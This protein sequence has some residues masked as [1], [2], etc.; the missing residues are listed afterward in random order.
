MAKK[1]QNAALLLSHALTDEK[2]QALENMAHSLRKNSKKIIT[3][4][5]KDLAMGK[6]KK[7]SKAL[8]D[9]LLLDEERIEKMA[10]SLEEII[11][12]PDPVGKIIQE[13]QPANRI[14]FK[15]IRIP[16]G[17]IGII[18][19]SRP[20]VTA[21][22]AGLCLKSG[23]AVILRGG[24]EAFHSNQ[25][26]ISLLSQAIQEANLPKE[27][28]QGPSSQDRKVI[29]HLLKLDS[30]I[31]LIIP[32]GG[33]ALVER[34][35]QKSRIPVLKHFKGICH[36]YLDE[37]ANPQMALDITLNAK[38][39]RPGVCNAIETLLVH[40]SL[41]KSILSGILQSLLESGVE[42]RADKELQNQ[43]PKIKLVKEK[44]F[45]NE[46]LDLILPIKIVSSIDEAIEHIQ[47][48]G[49]KHTE[50]IVT[51]NQENAERFI[52]EL[53]SSCIFVNAS[54][55]FADGG[56]MGM[57]A[58]IGISTSKIHAFGP[59]GLEDLT[60]ARYVGYGEG[61]IRT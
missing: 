6:G 43:F 40:K 37:S 39:Q 23:N 18:Y 1:A 46:F 36:L 15:K 54:T 47:K 3:A 38:V 11:K 5:Q 9:R 28:I 16:I 41:Q 12:L 61:Q 13:W 35:V 31:D 42:I 21:D 45:G 4:N 51:E 34:V 26:L 57:G 30:Y 20:N 29:D 7:L 24:S 44:D 22:A 33:Q 52:K 50:G 25:I 10:Y 8:S 58:E 56:E 55:R 53:D 27:S 17:V 32:R 49:S 14:Q 19:E 59:M 48:Y 2:N 60:I